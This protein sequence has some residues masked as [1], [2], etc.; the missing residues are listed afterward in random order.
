MGIVNSD[1]DLDKALDVALTAAFGC[2]AGQRAHSLG[3]LILHK[4]IA[5]NFTA[6]FIAGASDVTIGEPLVTGVDM[7]PLVSAQQ[8]DR[9]VSG[10]KDLLAAGGELLLGDGQKMAAPAAGLEGG[11]WMAP[12][13]IGGFTGADANKDAIISE[14]QGPVVKIIVVEDLKEAVNAANAGPNGLSASLW[15]KDSDMAHSA[16]QAIDAGYVWV[17]N[18]LTRDLSM[19]FGGWK[20]SGNGQRSGGT[21]DVDFY[22]YTKTVCMEVTGRH[23]LMA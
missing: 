18:W 3:R 23:K 22:S 21:W 6:K 8:V 2:D 17:N 5:T 11:N 19:P 14:H 13:I 9:M 7:G 1:A 15:S 20:D 4:D 12:T 10:V 16:A